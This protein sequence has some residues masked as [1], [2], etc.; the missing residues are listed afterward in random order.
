MIKFALAN[1][2]QPLS[3]LDRMSLSWEG[4]MDR[5]YDS[6]VMS[7]SEFEERDLT[8]EKQLVTLH[9]QWSKSLQ[10]VQSAI[11]NTTSILKE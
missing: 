5:L 2:P 9:T 7:T 4:A 6:M 8:A 3:D 11:F 10:F 1:D